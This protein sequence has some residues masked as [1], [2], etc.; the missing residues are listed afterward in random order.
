MGRIIK[1]TYPVM[2]KLEKYI[3]EI[4]S[5][6]DSGILTNNGEK[7]DKF[8]QMLLEYTM[9]SNNDLFVN[10]HSALM[11]AIKALGLRGE[12]ITSPFTFVSTTNAIVQNG[13]IPVFG[14]I[15]DSYNLS[16]ESIEKLITDK[17]SAI[18]TPH[19]FGIPCD[20]NKIGHIAE[21]YNLKVIYDGAQAFG[22]RI[23]GTDISCF[24][25]ITMFS[26]HAIKIF[27]SIE[28]GMLS[29]KDSSLHEKFE[30]YRNFGI[31]YGIDGRDD[32][33]CEGI[34]AKMN[35]FQ[36]AMGI[37]NLPLL[38]EEIAQRKELAGIYIEHLREIPGISTYSYQ[39]RID[40]NYA[41]FPILVEEEYGMTRD[42]LWEGLREEGIGSRKLYGSLT[43]DYSIY[44]ERGFR[45]MTEYADR[46]K[47]KC[48]DLP[49]YG[50]LTKENVEGICQII[51]K[52][53]KR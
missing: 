34:N 14:D 40:Y 12:V 15:D 28:G 24:G 9:C 38:Q 10:G 27:N 11:I 30:Q 35:E 50:G 7:V 29:Y 53:A 16:P 23:D 33:E 25:D 17:T 8:K 44:R 41:Y 39:K 20:V 1:P 45:R 6:W 37:V 49:L 32:V 43:C 47:K 26:F 36:A 13:L 2:P 22:T 51:G 46:V 42:Q 19:I 4:S 21:K 5:I 48:L 18:I 52:L 3:E 31:H